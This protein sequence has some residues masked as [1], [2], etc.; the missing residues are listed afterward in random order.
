MT[1]LFEE[2]NLLLRNVASFYS[3]KEN[4]PSASAIKMA[5]F[6]IFPF[7]K[8]HSFWEIHIRQSS[9]CVLKKLL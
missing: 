7:A 2:K 6:Y 9:G 1:A 3:H 5:F 4:Y 8:L